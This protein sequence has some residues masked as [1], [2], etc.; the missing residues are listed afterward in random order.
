MI[1]MVWRYRHYMDI[2]EEAEA[3]FNNSD[4]ELVMFAVLRR[5]QAFKDLLKFQI[6]YYNKD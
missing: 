6:K 1:D 5:R 2:I 4:S 3:C